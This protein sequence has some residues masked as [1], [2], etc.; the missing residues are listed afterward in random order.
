MT[1]TCATRKDRCQYH[2]LPAPC[3]VVARALTGHKQGAGYAYGCPTQP[4]AVAMA[5]L[6]VNI[7]HSS[8]MVATACKPMICT[9]L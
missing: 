1:H 4:N 3:A 5:W 6:G 8:T 7:L 9:E 2:A